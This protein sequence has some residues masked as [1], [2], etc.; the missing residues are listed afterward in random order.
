MMQIVHAIVKQIVH[1]IVKEYQTHA[2]ANWSPFP[3]SIWLLCANQSPTDI[4]LR[5]EIDETA[6][7]FPAV[8]HVWSKLFSTCVVFV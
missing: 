8:L 6:R 7:M 3:L 5:E 4:L 1:A 2:A